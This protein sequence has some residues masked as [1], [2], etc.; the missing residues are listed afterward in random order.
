MNL[1]AYGVLIARAG[2]PFGTSIFGILLTLVLVLVTLSLLIKIAKAG[3]RR[4]GFIPFVLVII[5]SIWMYSALSEVRRSSKRETH[6]AVALRQSSAGMIQSDQLFLTLRDADKLPEEVS[7]VDL[8]LTLKQLA[9]NM[10]L[11]DMGKRE[12]KRPDWLSL[13]VKRMDEGTVRLSDVVRSREVRRHHEGQHQEDIIDLK[14][15]G[16]DADRDFFR[17]TANALQERIA[18]EE[19]PTLA[20][21]ISDRHLRIRVTHDDEV[22]APVDRPIDLAGED[23]ERAQEDAAKAIEEALSEADL[24]FQD[25]EDIISTALNGIYEG[26]AEAKR[27]HAKGGNQEKNETPPDDAVVVAEE[28]ELDA[29]AEIEEETDLKTVETAEKQ[30]VEESTESPAKPTE[31]ASVSTSTPMILAEQRAANNP[32]PYAPQGLSER[33]DYHLTIHAGPHKNLDD[34]EAELA[35]KR[36]VALAAYAQKLLGPDASERLDFERFIYLNEI[37]ESPE[38]EITEDPQ[39]GQMYNIHS[40]L[41][42]DRNI[43][44]QL[45]SEYHDAVIGNR[46]KVTGVASAS[47]LL[48]LSAVFGYLKLDN[49]SR[50]Y[51]R[52]RLMAGALGVSFVV[53]VVAALALGN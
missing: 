51:Y 53:A 27:A 17:E 5:F 30:E 19:T 32:R 52:G 40:E 47:V 20:L 15:D 16:R 44:Q 45:R 35:E 24:D 3:V 2:F 12:K 50:G 37:P 25:V 38:T 23:Y 7:G 4:G 11:S 39:F 49:A 29:P 18:K 43:Q 10:A 13:P 42:F 46:L 14:V 22:P 48:L 6:T 41:T 8:A 21:E 34:C 1:D 33:G 31:V 36:Q 28:V 9:H 26:L